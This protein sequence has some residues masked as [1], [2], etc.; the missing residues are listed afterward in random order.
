M[1]NHKVTLKRRKSRNPLI[2]SLFG[3]SHIKTNTNSLSQP[4]LNPISQLPTTITKAIE[5]QSEIS[6]KSS[7][8]EPTIE[9]A[10]GIKNEGEFKHFSP[11]KVKK[12]EN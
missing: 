11:S 9:V 2:K 6:L 7:V 5:N 12:N 8:G 1:L 3:Q 10:I 4:L